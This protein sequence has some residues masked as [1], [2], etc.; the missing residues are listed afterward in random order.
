MTN[1]KETRG[2]KRDGAGRP[3]KEPTVTLSYRVSKKKAKQI[4]KKIKAVIT[5]INNS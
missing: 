1:K 2:G 3:K 5:K 4:D